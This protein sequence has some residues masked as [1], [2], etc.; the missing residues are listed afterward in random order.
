MCVY[1]HVVVVAVDRGDG[2]QCVLNKPLYFVQMCVYIHVV[3]VAVDREG[4]WQ[5]VCPE[6]TPLLCTDVCVHLRGSSRST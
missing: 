2:S 6:Q 5:S 4:R 1:I 3:V